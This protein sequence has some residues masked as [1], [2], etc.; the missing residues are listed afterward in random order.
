MAKSLMSCFF[1]THGVVVICMCMLLCCSSY[2]CT[3]LCDVAVT[4][5]LL[6]Q[7]V[8][9]RDR[10]TYEKIAD[11][12]SEN[13]NRQKLRD[14]MNCTKLPVIPYL[15]IRVVFDCSKTSNDKSV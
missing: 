7:M 5:V 1:L 9:K 15:G 6:S 11:L 14:Y 10:M 8:S 4:C 3:C 2:F 12:F 13:N